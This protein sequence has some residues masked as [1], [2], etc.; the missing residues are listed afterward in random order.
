[1]ISFYIF[2]LI[3]LAILNVTQKAIIINNFIILDTFRTYNIIIFIVII[4]SPKKKKKKKVFL[5]FFR[6]NK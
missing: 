4:I 2:E 1:M 5:K 3:S 6:I